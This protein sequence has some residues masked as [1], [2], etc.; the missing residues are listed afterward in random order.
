MKDCPICKRPDLAETEESCPQCGA[1][2]ECF[3]LLERLP[4]P[5][6]SEHAKEGKWFMST[7]P[8]LLVLLLGLIAIGGYFQLR[9]EKLTI[10]MTDIGEQIEKLE[11]ENFRNRIDDLDEK[12]ALAW[13]RIQAALARYG[14]PVSIDSISRP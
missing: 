1:D 3:G 9:M 13:Q 2:L 14:A 10:R 6:N 8:L 7:V 12:R 4:E 11:E 5:E